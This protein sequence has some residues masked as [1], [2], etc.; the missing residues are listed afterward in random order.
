MSGTVKIHN[1]LA[2]EKRKEMTDIIDEYEKKRK[3]DLERIRSIVDYTM[4]VLFVGLGIFFLVRYQQKITL[5]YLGDPDWLDIALGALFI[6]YGGWRL[7]RGYK[8]NYFR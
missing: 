1:L 8:K 6:L 2:P 7:Y 3:K 4:G 5:K